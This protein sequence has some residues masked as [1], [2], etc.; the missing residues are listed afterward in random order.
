MPPTLKQLQRQH[1]EYK[2]NSDR[3]NTLHRLVQGGLEFDEATKRKILANP[4]ARPAQVISE[5]VKV[6]RY[7]NKIGPI[8]NRF[9]SQLFA[10]EAAY[11]GSKDKFW[12]DSFFSGGALLPGDDDGRSSFHAFLRAAMLQAL[13][14]GKA[15]AQVD[16]NISTDVRSRAEQKSLRTDEPYVLLIP[17]GDLWDWASDRQGFRFA[18]IHKFNWVRDDWDSDPVAE[19]DFTIY[20]R[21]PDGKVLVSRYTVRV[22]NQQKDF[23]KGA[24]TTGLEHVADDDAEISVAY[25]LENA[26]VFNLSGEYS[27]PVVS[28][29]LPNALWIADQLHD[30]QV[31]HFNQTASLEYGLVAANYASLT[32]TSTDI[33]EFTQRNERFGA[34][35][36]IHLDPNN[37]DAVVWTERPGGAF[38]TSMNYREKIEADIDRTVQQIA[39]SAADAVST[40]SGEAIKQAKKP[41]MIL[42]STYGSMAKEFATSILNV[43]SVARGEKVKWKANGFSEFE[44]TNLSA[45]AQLYQLV[46]QAEIPSETFTKSYQ[47]AFIRDI[48]KTKEFDPEELKQM[49]EEIDQVKPSSDPLGGEG[50]DGETEANG[51]TSPVPSAEDV[52]GDVLN[53]PNLLAE[54]GI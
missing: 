19:H 28:L 17:R 20:Q 40:Q 16:T 53:D 38:E 48:A 14:T 39:L 52:A 9:L 54:L 4:D 25:G 33:E 3:W 23:D 37:Q 22:K 8:I 36:Y 42:L 50:V 6:A 34:G 46:K 32:I 1:T 27:F 44:E 24:I 43:A 47:K 10:T 30:P 45:T 12:T 11:E 13:S 15:I 7:F 5:R 51:A 26:Q 31:S 35:F 21:K 29:T 2:A 49:M 41:E 18:K